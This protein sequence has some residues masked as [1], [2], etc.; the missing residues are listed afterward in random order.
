MHYTDHF[1]LADQYFNHVDQTISGLDEFLKSRYIGFASISAVT[2]YEL[3]IKE[4]IYR[5]CDHKHKVLSH[6]S[7]KQFEKINARVRLDHLRSDY[8]S[9]FGD[10]Y[11][12]KFCMIIEK[13]ERDILKSAGKHIRSMYSNIIITRNEFAHAGIISSTNT[14]EEV[15]ERYS[16]GKYVIECFDLALQR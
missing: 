6:I 2:V 10:K 16:Y 4:I 11:E 7:R 8:L 12:K 5:F 9:F 3:A 1:A 15:R 14:Y 13:R